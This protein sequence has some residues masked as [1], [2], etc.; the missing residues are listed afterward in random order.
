MPGCLN[1]GNV[2][3]NIDMIV[4][5]WLDWKPLSVIL[6]HLNKRL[7]L[8]KRWDVLCDLG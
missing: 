8:E 5:L 7:G 2:F 4:S 3:V 1:S 6:L